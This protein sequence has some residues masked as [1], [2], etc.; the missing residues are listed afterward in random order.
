[1]TARAFPLEASG[2]DFVV[3]MDLLRR[4]KAATD[5]ELRAAG[6]PDIEELVQ[7]VADRMKVPRLRLGTLDLGSALTHALPRARAEK[8]R[9]VPVAIAPGE[10]TFATDDVT[11]TDVFA[12]LAKELALNV[13]IVAATPAEVDEALARLYRSR[14]I[15]VDDEAAQATVSAADIDRASELVERLI[16]DAIDAGA[17]DL[18]IEA[19]ENGTVVRIRVDGVLRTLD[20]RPK[21]PHAA[22]VSRIKILAM[23]DIAQRHT[24]Q[25]GRMQVQGADIRVSTLPTHYGEKAVC[26]ILDS[27]RVALPLAALDFEAEDLAVFL[28]MI[29]QP[30]GLLLVTGPAGSGKS[31]TLYGAINDIRSEQVN[32]C[33]IEDP[34][35]YQLPGINQVQVNTKRGLTFASALRSIL[36]Q[37]PNVILVGEMRDRETGTTAAEA[38]LTGHLVL[39]TLHTNDAAEAV[40][41][42]VELGIEPHTFAPALIGIVAQRLVRRVC[43]ECTERYRPDALE[44]ATLGLGELPAG[45]TFARG[46]GCSYCSGTGHRGRTAIREL[47][48]GTESI[49]RAILAGAATAEIRREAAR[50]GFRNLRFAALRKLFAGTTSTGEVLRLTR[51]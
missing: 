13:L 1:V 46:R 26:R 22:I 27:T 2:P 21:D 16:G 28:E 11:R 35:E 49:R 15:Q 6:F 24:P 38:A 48:P 25:D 50:Q 30:Y 40:T 43:P 8:L 34:I 39:S 32:I 9:M 45:A 3:G 7:A 19:S 10:I 20:V 14:P 17:S 42:L 18:H 23:L 12:W 31:T 36:R 47:L 44:L 37:D 29:R 5:E 51:S 41:R 4:R 33:T